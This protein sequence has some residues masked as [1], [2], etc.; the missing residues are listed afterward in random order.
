VEQWHEQWK[1]PEIWNQDG[2]RKPF[3]KPVLYGD[4]IE[5]RGMYF[6]ARIR[7]LKCDGKVILSDTGLKIEGAQDVVLALAAASSFQWLR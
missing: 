6:E 5:N 3:A 4:E 1:Y 7:V 2:T